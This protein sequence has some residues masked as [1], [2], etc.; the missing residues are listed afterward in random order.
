MINITGFFNVLAAYNGGPCKPPGTSS[1]L[2]L[3]YWYSYL[4]GTWQSVG[5][6]LV[7]NPSLTH[8]SDIWLVVAAVIEILL[9]LA[10]I[11][12]F[13]MIIIGGI[14]FIVS[15]G[16]PQQTKAARESMINAAIGL[17]IVTTAAFIVT[18]IANRL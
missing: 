8:L 1:F 3:P 9:R 14:R 18:F 16:N 5:S 11:I 6:K 15:Q 2:G 17:L 12:A 7:C 13:V 4:P 10:G